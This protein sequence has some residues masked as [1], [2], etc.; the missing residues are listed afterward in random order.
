MKKL[1]LFALFLSSTMVFSQKV[2]EEA[3]ES[4]ELKGVKNLKISLPK[5]YE[6]D[7][8]LKYPLTII[9]GNQHLFDIYVGNSK[10]FANRDA[11]PKQIVVGVETDRLKGGDV[12]TVQRNGWL[13]NK[14]ERFYKF[15]TKELI[16]HLEGKYKTSPFLTIVGEGTA[17]NFAT[18]F[19]REDNLIFNSYVCVNPIFNRNTRDVISSFKLDR[20]EDVDNTFYLY[21]NTNS[22]MPK[23]QQDFFSDFKNTIESLEI[24][25][26]K[27][28]FDNFKSPNS[29]SS[30][31]ESVPRALNETFQE[32]SDISKEEYE[33]NIKHLEPLDVIAYLERKQLN[34]EYLFGTNMGIR[35]KDIFMVE[36]SIIDKE[37]GKYLKFLGEILL[38]MYPKLHLGD[39][40]MGLFHEKQGDLNKAEYHYKVGYRKIDPSSPK[41]D[42]FYK[43][44]TRV[45]K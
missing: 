12:A 17:A 13:T 3:Y 14:A 27:S 41:A 18:Y 36:S 22:F 39:Y 44:I 43:N 5:G 30:L 23:S 42:I 21:M 37:N 32:Y 16:P 11:A 29:M 20:L 33:K 7:S 34:I 15:I 25:N 6:K 28:K 8:I 1:F 40:Y 9:L 19:L 2:S 26:L 10:I 45:T 4:K 38:K 24:K 31:S 35:E